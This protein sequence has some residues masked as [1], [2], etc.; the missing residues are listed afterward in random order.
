MFSQSSPN[1]KPVFLNTLL[2]VYAEFKL[3]NEA[4]ELY[5]LV[6]GEGNFPSTF[7]FNLF[8]ECLVNSNKFDETLRIFSDAVNS[9]VW[10][11]QFSYGKAIQSAVKLGDLRRGFGLMYKMN[12]CGLRPNVFVYNVL[13]RKSV[14]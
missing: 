9:G 5:S 7:A 14:V 13:D 11:D 6:R 8:L 12:E 10:V 2:A 1:T 4:I 3:H